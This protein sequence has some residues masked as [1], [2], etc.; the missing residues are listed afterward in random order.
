MKEREPLMNYLL[1]SSHGLTRIDQISLISE[2]QELYP[3]AFESIKSQCLELGE[4]F[5]NPHEL[6]EL[7]LRI[8]GQPSEEC[9]ESLTY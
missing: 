3:Q 8:V 7:Q 6:L 5:L 4:Q 1:E 9:L 2:L